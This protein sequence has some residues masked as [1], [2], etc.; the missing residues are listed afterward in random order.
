MFYRERPE[1]MS[2]EDY[3]AWDQ[4]QWRDADDALDEYQERQEQHKYDDGA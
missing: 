4:Q 2:D 3:E 1:E